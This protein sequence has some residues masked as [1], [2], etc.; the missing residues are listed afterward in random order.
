MT[1]GCE[2]RFM[3]VTNA[4]LWWGM[5]TVEGSYTVLYIKGAMNL[6]QFSQKKKKKKLK[7]SSFQ[8]PKV[9]GQSA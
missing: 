2:S 7:L 3:D 9:G 1:L 4:L 5:L 6:K 8:G